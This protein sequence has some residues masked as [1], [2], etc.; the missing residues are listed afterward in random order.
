VG[1]AF[2]VGDIFYSRFGEHQSWATSTVRPVG[3]LVAA[4]AGAEAAAPAAAWAGTGLAAA[5]P[6][7]GAASLIPGVG[8]VVITGALA[9]AAGYAADKADIWVWDHRAA[10]GQY[11]AQTAVTDYH[12]AKHVVHDLEPWNW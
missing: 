3:T 5:L 2:T 11:V 9:C 6:E 10:I 4:T 7:V 8:E 1:A 12:I